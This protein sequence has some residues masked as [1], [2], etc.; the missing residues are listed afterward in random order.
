MF[1]YAKGGRFSGLPAATGI[2]VRKNAE[3]R[4]NQ[5]EGGIR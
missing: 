3:G 5:H 4:R 1:E 2:R